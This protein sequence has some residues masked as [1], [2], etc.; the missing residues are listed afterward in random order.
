MLD[1][2]FMMSGKIKAWSV[3]SKKNCKALF[4]KLYRKSSQITVDPFPSDGTHN[5]NNDQRPR[6]ELRD[7][8]SNHTGA[9]KSTGVT[10]P[11]GDSQPHQPNGLR[12][13]TPPPPPLLEA[14]AK[15][16]PEPTLPL[17]TNKHWSPGGQSVDLKRV[18]SSL[19]E[20]KAPILPTS[21]PCKL[22]VI[23]DG[24]ILP[25]HEEARCYWNDAS[26]FSI[27]Q[28]VAERILQEQ[29]YVQLEEESA[30]LY[31]R[32]GRC[33]LMRSKDDFEV[34]SI[35]IEN[36][37]QWEQYL[38]LM[39]AKFATNNHFVPFYLDFR[40]EYSL[41]IIKRQPGVAYAET[42]RGVLY[43]RRQANYR[44]QKYFPRQVLDNLFKTSTV[45]ELIDQDE[46]LRRLAQKLLNESGLAWD[47]EKFIAHVIADG[48]V[49]LALCIYARLPLEC[50]YRLMD[51]YKDCTTTLKVSDCPDGISK[52]DFDHLVELQGG[53]RAHTFFNDG[54]HPE[55]QKLDNNTVVPIKFE[56]KKDLIGRGG[57]GEVFRVHIDPD[58][59]QFSPVGRHLR[60]VWLLL[61]LHASLGSR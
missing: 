25:H 8:S 1:C 19:A 16:P 7:S 33:R 30:R 18:D 35:I 9:E 38:P 10:L 59:H 21:V 20:F 60:M 41:L 48:I 34:E 49:Y 6:Q 45:R 32:A 23:L 50:L 36:K 42:V 5:N 13:R 2:L 14:R 46:S 51:K 52:P 37:R 61:I 57:F 43:D 29:S 53:F 4:R 15:N 47:K 27:L 44:D 54:R 40:W 3:T 31:K 17:P 24:K 39:V 28:S 55:H 11:H 22:F 56:E 12:S 58:H 26:Y